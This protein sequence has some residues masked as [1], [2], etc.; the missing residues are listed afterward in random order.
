MPETD[1]I[2]TIEQWGYRP[3]G[4]SKLFK[5]KP[6]EPLPE[7]W[8]PTPREEDH[9][10]NQVQRAEPA[11][12]SPLDEAADT[13]ALQDRIATLESDIASLRSQNANQ[14]H[15][16]ETA[17]KVFA[18]QRQ[19]IAEQEAEIAR[20]L[21]VT[22]EVFAPATTSAPEGTT[23]TTEAAKPAGGKK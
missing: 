3:G 20:L 15:E 12:R 21:A 4:E 17:E 19:Q 18:S 2:E 13:K 8:S 11:P 10:N 22:P 9:P 6:Y 1:A 5:L 14:A 23:T 16:L 7:G